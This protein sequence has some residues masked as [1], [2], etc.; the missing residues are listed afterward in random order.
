MSVAHAHQQTNQIT[1][2][3]GMIL[4][5]FWGLVISIGSMKSSRKKK[6]HISKTQINLWQGMH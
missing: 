3:Y 4:V 5:T 2:Q 6:T 1:L